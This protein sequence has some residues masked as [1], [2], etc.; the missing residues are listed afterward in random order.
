MNSKEIRVYD[1]IDKKVGSNVAMQGLSGLAGFP[2]TVI[3]DVAVLF[4]HYGPMLNEIRVVYGRSPITKTAFGP[5]LNGCK[6]ELLTDMVLDKIV[7]NIPLIGL[8][9]NMICA[10]A[11]T[12]RLGILFGM[13][14]ARGEDINQQNVANAVQLIR[15][16][17]PQKNSLMFQKPSAGTVEKLLKT[18]DG[19]SVETFDQK[20]NYI[21]DALAS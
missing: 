6:R 10:K 9:A 18:V 13:L 7:G 15:K 2:F 12:W 8:P 5:V 20:V 19:D 14:A 11:M 21:L 16:L 1:I 17:F 3:T 4:S